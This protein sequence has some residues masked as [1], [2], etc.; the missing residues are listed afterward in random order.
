MEHVPRPTTARLEWIDV[1]RGISILRIVFFH[2]FGTYTNGY[3]PSVTG[4]H[5][6][7]A[8]FSKCAPS[9]ALTWTGCLLQ[10]LLVGLDGLGFHAVGVFILLSGFGLT[11]AFAGQKSSPESWT[12]WYRARLIR[13]FPIYW[14]AH[15]IYL[16]SPFVARPEG[17]DYRFALSLLGDRFYPVYSIFY[18]VNP[19]W[20]YF[21]LL[22]QLYLV[23]PLLFILL[24][25]AGV[26]W[27]LV[28]CGIETIVS[29][30]LLLV[31]FPTS[32]YYV[33]GAF[34]GCRLW[35]FAAGMGLGMMMRQRHE[36]TK[37]ALFNPVTLA[38]G[39][40]IYALGLYSYNTLTTYTVTDALTGTGLFIILSH[41]GRWSLKL[42]RVSA[43][44]AYVGTY[45]YAL[46]LLHQ[47]YV[48]YVGERVRDL[49]GPTFLLVAAVIIAILAIVS[50]ALERNVN[51]LV[52]RLLAPSPIAETPRLDA[53][54]S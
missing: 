9:S 10:S 13:L 48:I 47:P 45:S 33:Q 24:R 22:I 49:N 8:F 38:T 7:A 1:I 52:N 31:V 50:A 51:R 16:F 35:E 14:L 19:A 36:S 6:F 11:Y 25:R 5:Y 42:G 44:V 23:F 2:F 15:L 46:Y 4:K 17:I 18:Y 27:F 32:G 37:G 53:A 54:R 39:I 26:F 29:R 34:F 43:A 28:L 21:G 3:Y 40:V 12:G 30:Y 41:V 20:W